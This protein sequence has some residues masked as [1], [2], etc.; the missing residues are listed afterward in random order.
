MRPCPR[1][2]SSL[3]ALLAGAGCF[4]DYAPNI[5]G[6]PG[7]SSSSSDTTSSGSSTT[8]TTGESTSASTGDPLVDSLGGSESASSTGTTSATTIVLPETGAP[9]DPYDQCL[10]QNGQL[11]CGDCL[12][13]KC[14]DEYAD[15]AADP[16]CVAIETCAAEY[17][18]SD[19]QCLEPC[20]DVIAM[21][22]GLTGES[23]Q[24]AI[25]LSNCFNN[26]C[27]GP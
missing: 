16:G 14:L 4:T 7:A 5:T 15:C 6:E 18:C 10:A 26:S 19:Y 2:P 3:L 17:G 11:E 20:S 13:D 1:S 21:N 24:L 12:C 23:I 9:A 8:G 25:A 27:C 22:G